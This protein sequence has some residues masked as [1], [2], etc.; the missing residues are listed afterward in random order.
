MSDTWRHLRERLGRRLVMAAYLATLALMIVAVAR[1][2]DSRTGFGHLVTFGDIQHLPRLHEVEQLDYY[3]QTEGAGDDGQYYAQIAM[4]PGLR[5]PELPHTIDAIA[6]RARRILFCWIAY[7]LGLGRPA[8]ILQAYALENVFA[9]F[10]LAAILLWW[11]PA[12]SWQNYVRWAGVLFCGGMCLS[13]RHA[14]VDGP[15]LLLIAL[16]VRCIEVGRPWL[17]AL[18]GGLG[19]LGRETNVLAAIA[20]VSSWPRDRRSLVR[21]TLL[22]AAVVVPLLLWLVYIR[23][24]VGPAINVG[25]RNFSLPLVA[26]LERGS[27]VVAGLFVPGW[28]DPVAIGNLV[29]FVALSAQLLFLAFRWRPRDAWWR[30]GSVFAVLMLVLGDAVWEGYPGAA[31]RVLLPMQLAFN[32]LVPRTPRWLLVLVLGNLTVI[33]APDFLQP[34]PGAGYRVE[35]SSS[36]APW[37][38]GAAHVR[39]TFDRNWY[40]PEHHKDRQWRWASGNASFTIVNPRS[41]PLTASIGF[42]LDGL[43]QRR[44]TFERDGLNL[45]TGSIDP[46]G[47]EVKVGKL[48]LSPGPNH[49][50]ITTDRPAKF[51]QARDP[52]RLAFSLRNLEIR[53]NHDAK[54]DGNP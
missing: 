10:A 30:V 46:G 25:S 34:P 14:F 4:H 6:Y 49:F 51:V 20:F 11:F 52:R 8:W 33:S 32:V 16:M 18:V 3:L 21:L 40:Q 12:T 48:V 24:T 37:L 45:W 47:V 41:T 44:G 50:T 22:G 5:D 2:Y 28:H 13:V 39:V 15:S 7:G 17:G 35:G 38:T 9:W 19:A 27:D 43:D 1:F 31:V 36:F 23:A 26:Y 29:S 54:P 42:H 53:L